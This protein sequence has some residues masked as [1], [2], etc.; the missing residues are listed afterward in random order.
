M[1]LNRA[2]WHGLGRFLLLI[3]AA[4]TTSLFAEWNDAKYTSATLANFRNH[5]ELNRV[6]SFENPDYRSIHAAIY[7]VTNEIRVKNKL[8]A[9]EYSRNLEIAAYNHAKHMVEGGFFAHVNPRETSR[10]DPEARARLAGILNPH[11]AENIAISFAIRYKAGAAIY[12]R[13][14]GGFSYTP[15]GPIIET[16]TAL[17]FADAV[18]EQ[19]MN[20]AG[21]RANIL[22]PKAK[23]VG[24]GAYL[25]IDTASMN[26][27]K[28][29]AVQNFQ[30]FDPI[31]AGKAADKLP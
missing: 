27:R 1:I 7:F 28:I 18:L 30:F 24:A 5:A 13:E 11:I 14:N 9:L 3:S 10:K 19:W 25:Y 23:S 8:P 2:R 31:Q 6:I 26:M 15:K 4:L 21:H 20:S 12:P 29:K 16:H 22:S 17:S